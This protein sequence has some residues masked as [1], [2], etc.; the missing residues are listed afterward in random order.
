M[1]AAAARA[2]GFNDLAAPALD[3]PDLS[4]KPAAPGPAASGRKAQRRVAK[5]AAA[6]AAVLDA[7]LIS[8]GAAA[9]A[10]AALKGTCDAALGELNEAEGPQGVVQPVAAG[11]SA[12]LGGKYAG[13]LP[14]LTRR[15]QAVVLG[16]GEAA[17]AGTVAGA[18]RCA[19]V[20]LQLFTVARSVFYQLLTPPVSLRCVVR[21]PSP[22]PSTPTPSPGAAA[23]DGLAGEA[24]ERALALRGDTERGARARKKKALTDLL[25]ALQAAGVSRR[26]TAVPPDFRGTQAW[27]RQVQKGRGRQGCTLPTCG[28]R[29]HARLAGP[30]CPQTERAV[31]PPW[32]ANPKSRPWASF[33]PRRLALM[34]QRCWL[35]QRTV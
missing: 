27:F 20:S 21:P 29:A 3:L 19:H 9:A 7:A 25:K 32:H 22:H 2:M 26:R 24:A 33:F 4:A 34:P 35:R 1:L 18:C 12:A 15:F 17:A 13:Q 31:P 14:R 5:E 28:A 11:G 30:G 23:I 10:A 8:D 16:G 6:A